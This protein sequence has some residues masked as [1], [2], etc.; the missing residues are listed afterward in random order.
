M[1]WTDWA[2]LSIFILG[3]LLFLIGAN[4][5]NAIIGYSGIYLFIGAIAAYLMIYAYKELTKKMPIQKP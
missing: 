1:T 3:F 5:Y 4:I 2:C